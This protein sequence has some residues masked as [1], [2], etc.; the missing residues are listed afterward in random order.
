MK[1]WNTLEADIYLIMNTHYTHGRNGRRID[2]VIIH[3]NAGNF[4]IRSCYDVWQTRPASTHYQ[5]Q[6][7]GTISQLVW[8]CDTAWHAGYF[9]TNTTSIGIE[10]TVKADPDGRWCLWCGMKLPQRVDGVSLDLSKYDFVILCLGLEPNGDIP[11]ESLRSIDSSI[12]EREY[13]IGA[14]AKAAI[15]PVA[16]NIDGHRVLAERITKSFLRW[17]C[18]LGYE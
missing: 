17:K 2:K 7:D 8:D 10:P 14:N 3:H 1:N 6:S 5:V 18:G 11:R 12:G 16:R 13:V 4:T 15:G 9:A